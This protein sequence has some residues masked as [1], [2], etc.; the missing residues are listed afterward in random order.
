[1]SVSGSYLLVTSAPCGLL[2]TCP[3]HPHLISARPPGDPSI[4]L[5][6]PHQ[7]LFGD[8]LNSPQPVGPRTMLFLQRQREW[9]SPA[10]RQPATAQSQGFP[11]SFWK[12]PI[13]LGPSYSKLYSKWIDAL[14]GR[15]D[16]PCPHRSPRLFLT[17][18]SPILFLPGLQTEARKGGGGAA[19]RSRGAPQGRGVSWS[20]MA[21]IPP[22]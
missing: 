21:P 20:K 4:G 2:G 14:W 19:P 22:K 9:S 12:N 17:L 13:S 1:M 6:K 3:L 16:A 7:V 8:A 18:P 5:P 11:E 15:R 10:Y